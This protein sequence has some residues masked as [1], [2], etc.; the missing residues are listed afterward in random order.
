MRRR[1]INGEDAQD[2]GGRHGGGHGGL[3]G[4]GSGRGGGGRADPGGRRRIWPVKVPWRRSNL[5]GELEDWASMAL[6]LSSWGEGEMRRLEREEREKAGDGGVTW[7]VA[8]GGAGRPTTREEGWGEGAL[9]EELGVGSSAGAGGGGLR[10][11][12]LGPG[13]AGS[14]LETFSHFK[15]A[16]G[17]DIG[18][19]FGFYA[20]MVTTLGPEQS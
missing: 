20:K 8:G 9:E 19:R 6:A 18:H 5:Q 13:R 12:A 7:M 4:A 11:A 3:G 1:R 14:G 15:K 17:E 10:A 2:L 16:C